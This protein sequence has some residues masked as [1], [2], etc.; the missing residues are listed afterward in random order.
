MSAVIV[1]ASNIY[2]RSFLEFFFFFLRISKNK[3]LICFDL[4]ELN[5][6]VVYLSIS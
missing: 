1:K 4:T 2:I 3:T 5:L 6:S